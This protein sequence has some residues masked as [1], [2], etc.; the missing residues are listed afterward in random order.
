MGWV[1]SPKKQNVKVSDDIKATVNDKASKVV[2]LLRQKHINPANNKEGFN[3]IVDIYSKWY[4]SYFYLCSKY[5]TNSNDAIYPSYEVKFARMEYVDNH[6]FN[7]SYMRHT[8][9]WQEIYQD[10]SV[11]ECFD[12][13]LN[14]GLFL[15]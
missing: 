2:E 11:D 9:K 15:I 12:V 8:G 10:L 6:K 4:R 13:I 1:Y 7:L 14:E 3:Y 5:E